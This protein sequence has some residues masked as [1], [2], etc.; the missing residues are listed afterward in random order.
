MKTMKSYP[1]FFVKF[2]KGMVALIAI[3]I[4]IVIGVSIFNSC[5]NNEFDDNMNRQ[6]N[7]NFRNALTYNKKKIG[8]IS[9]E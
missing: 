9:L 7:S 3:N 8:S 5:K 4:F 6:A 2:T 1:N